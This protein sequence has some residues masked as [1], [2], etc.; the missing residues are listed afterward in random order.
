[1]CVRHRLHG[2]RHMDGRRRATV[3][4]QRGCLRG[5]RDGCADGAPDQSRKSP[6]DFPGSFHL[7]VQQGRPAGG[8][9]IMALCTVP[10]DRRGTDRLRADRRISARHIKG[11]GVALLSGLPCQKRGGQRHPLFHKT[12]RFRS[13]SRPYGGHLCDAR[14]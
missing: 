6:D 13:S 8:A 4:H 11:T 7:R 10:S 14:V 2:G 3:R 12:G 5:F 1:M 9:C